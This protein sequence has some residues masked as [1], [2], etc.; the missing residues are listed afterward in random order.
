MPYTLKTALEALASEA[1]INN[2]FREGMAIFR[3]ISDLENMGIEL[4]KIEAPEK[5]ET[6][7]NKIAKLVGREQ[8]H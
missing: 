4:D 8:E 3:A 5:A 2:G 1:Q 6:E 7:I